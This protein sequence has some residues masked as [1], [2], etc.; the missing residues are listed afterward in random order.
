MEL[1]DQSSNPNEIVAHAHAVK[2]HELEYHD[3]FV[4]I[5]QN[6]TRRRVY[7]GYHFEDTGVHIFVSTFVSHIFQ[8]KAKTRSFLVNTITK[9]WKD[10]QSVII[11]KHKPEKISPIENNLIKEL[12]KP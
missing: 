10:Y 4:V 2:Y 8:H 9:E 1:K 12:Q 6:R 7:N 3:D 5:T 11:E